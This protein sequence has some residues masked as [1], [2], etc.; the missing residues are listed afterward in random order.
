MSRTPIVLKESY[1]SCLE[2]FE[3]EM[4]HLL[5]IAGEWFYGSIANEYAKLKRNLAVLTKKIVRHTPL[6]SGLLYNILYKV[7]NANKLR[8]LSAIWRIHHQR[9]KL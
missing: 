8:A 2:K 5:A 7:R 3:K 4:N 1:A 9:S 6:K